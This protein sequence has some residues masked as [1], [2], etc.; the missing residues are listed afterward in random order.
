MSPTIAGV[1]LLPLGNGAPDVFASIAAFMGTN[2]GDVG[3][4]GVLGAAVFVTCIVVGVV[5]LCV[6]EKRVQ[7]DRK[8][9]I[10]DICFF[11][12]AISCLALI[13]VV[14]EV[15]IWGAMAFVSI[16]VVYAFF[17]ALDE[18][19]K[20]KGPMLKLDGWTP[21]LPVVGS[22]FGSRGEEEEEEDESMNA[23]LLNRENSENSPE[24]S[25]KLP[26]WVWNSSVAIYSDYMKVNMEDSSSPPLW[27]WTEETTMKEE[28]SSSSFANVCSFLEIP[29][30]VP[31]RLT[32]PIVEEDRWSKFYAVASATLS[33]M[34]L[35]FL[36]NTQDNVSPSSGRVAYF[37][38]LCVGSML[39]L[40]ALIYTSSDHPPRRFLL[41][42]VIGGFFMSIIWFYLAANEIVSLLISLGIIFGINPSILALTILAWGNSMGDLT[43]NTALAMNQRDGVQI[44]VSGSYAGPMFNT[45]IGLG[46]SM[47]L[48]ASS[49][50]SEPYVVPRDGSL[51]ITMGFLVAGLI[52]ALIVLPLSDMKPNKF[53]GVGL[54]TIYLMFLGLRIGSAMGLGTLGGGGVK[55]V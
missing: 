37:V 43:A 24:V 32:I 21:L 38:C 33:P 16:Y 18:I 19:L 46:V 44:A 45:L 51:F 30:I 48:G 41:P 6:A 17:V 1:T 22:L 12:F 31:R 28:G 4:N 54:I 9:F 40:L 15:N 23:P 25:S 14:G 42:W 27:G 11:L 36:W 3:I 52:W 39:G 47:F 10:R 34:V 35:A 26:H 49:M 2:S 5:S 29:L 55:L 20:K 7:I 50:G 13:L 53:L 8:C